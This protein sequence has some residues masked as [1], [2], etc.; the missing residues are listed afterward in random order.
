M[1]SSSP[2]W[3]TGPDAKTCPFIEAKGYAKGS[4][5]EL[6]LVAHDANSTPSRVRQRHVPAGRKA[7]ASGYRSDS[8][9]DSKHESKVGGCGAGCRRR[10]RSSRTAMVL[11]ISTPRPAAHTTISNRIRRTWA[12]GIMGAVL[13]VS[14]ALWRC[15][16]GASSSKT[17]KRRLRASTVL[18]TAPLDSARE[19]HK[20]PRGSPN[21]GPVLT[22][23]EL[24]RVLTGHLTAAN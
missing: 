5:R 22:V 9:K 14:T 19:A 3:G 24:V 21:H 23:P 17:R 18:L 2:E 13:L 16:S 15:A 6:R 1:P 11:V 8:E 7:S 20:M 12:C 10:T 4:K